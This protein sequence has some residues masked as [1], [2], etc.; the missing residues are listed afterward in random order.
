MTVEIPDDF[1]LE[2][3]RLSGQCF[4][5]RRFE[6]ETLYGN[7][8]RTETDMTR[9]E[10]AQQIAK[11]DPEQPDALD[12]LSALNETDYIERGENLNDP[13]VVDDLY[14]SAM[15]ELERYKEKYDDLLGRINSEL[16]KAGATEAQI[17][18]GLFGDVELPTMAYLYCNAMARKLIQYSFQIVYCLGEL[19]ML[20]KYTDRVDM[21]E[22]RKIRKEYRRR[23]G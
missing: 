6:D 8:R 14:D 17:N 4:R 21:E 18:W 22:V 23:F 20:S 1:D 13:D 12:R 15:E 19:Q 16:R 11:I 7:S 9:K 5:I 2:K 3:I 10:Y